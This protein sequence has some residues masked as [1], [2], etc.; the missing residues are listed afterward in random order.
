[1]SKY[2]IRIEELE[3]MLYSKYNNHFTFYVSYLGMNYCNVIG[4]ILLSS[5]VLQVFSGL[6]LSIY[7]DDFYTIAFDPVV[8]IMHDVNIGWFIRLYHCIGATLFMFFMFIHWIRGAWIGFKVIESNIRSIRVSGRLIF[9]L[10]LIEGFLG[11]VLN[12]GQMSYRGITVMINIVSILPLFGNIVSELIWCTSHVIINRIYVFHFV[13]GFFISFSILFHIDIEGKG[14]IHK[15]ITTTS[16]IF[17]THHCYIGVLYIIS[18]LIGGSFGYGLPTII[19]LELALPGFLIRSSLQ[20]NTRITFHGLFMIFFMIMPILIG[21]FG[22]LPLP[23]LLCS[24]DMIFPRLNALSLWLVIDSLYLMFLGITID[25]GVNAGWTFYV[26]LSIMNSSS[27]DFM[28]FSLHLVGLSPLSGSINFI[29]TSLKASSLS[30]ISMSL[31]LPLFPRSIFFTSFLLSI[32]LPVPAGCIT[33]IISD[34][35]FNTSFSDPLRGGDLLPLQH[36]FWFSS[37]PEVHILILPAFGL[38]SE[39]LSKSSQCIIFGR[40]S[41]IIA[42]LVIPFLGC[43]VR[44][45]HMSMVGFDIVTLAY[46]T[47]A[48]PIIAIP[49]GIKIFNRLATLWTGCLYLITPQFFII[50]FLFSFSFGGFTGLMLANCIIDTLLHDSYFIVGHFHYVP[51]SGAVYTI[52]SAFYTYYN[53][54]SSTSYVLLLS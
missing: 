41:M 31:F 33:T 25:G 7:Y 20:Y 39:M 2:G 50:G 23:L 3:W 10:S 27:I 28:I 26:P 49:T 13:I 19:R 14:I 18:G 47:T 30:V 38:I 5:F 6:C 29:C 32:T 48:T 45:H 9:I 35:H 1:L 54:F 53:Y 8:Y 36:L 24:S 52:F 46:Y 12:R 4:F 21:G 15:L 34:R 37:H 22:N 42:L 51:S 11:H 16:L 44:G 43:I 17:S 40:D